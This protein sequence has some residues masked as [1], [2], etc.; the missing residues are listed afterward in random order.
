[1]NRHES[2]KIDFPNDD[3]DAMILAMDK[4]VQERKLF[5]EQLLQKAKQLK[6]DTEKA[7]VAAEIEHKKT[8]LK[9]KAKRK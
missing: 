2:L 3:I 4:A 8:I 6:I 7:K 9:N 5:C 1:M